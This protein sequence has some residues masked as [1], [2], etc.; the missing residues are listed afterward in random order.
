M[1]SMNIPRLQHI[2][3]FTSPI[4]F[5]NWKSSQL[6][7][8]HRLVN[9]LKSEK[10][11]FIQ[12]HGTCSEDNEDT[13]RTTIEMAKVKDSLQLQFKMKDMGELH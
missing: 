11:L 3:R 1:A 12:R 9:A 4:I 8:N 2:V 5:V 13:N 6:H 7:D 10:P